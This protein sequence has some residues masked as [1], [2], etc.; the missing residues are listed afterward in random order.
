MLKAL[1]GILMPLLVLKTGTLLLAKLL[2]SLLIL[3][4]CLSYL[5]PATGDRSF[6]TPPP[7]RVRLGDETE[8]KL[9][10]HKPTSLNDD[11]REI[12]NAT[13]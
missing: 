7:P 2:A 10:E 8:G 9:Q 5:V 13:S 12:T 1:K 6:G 3:R 11:A 4:H